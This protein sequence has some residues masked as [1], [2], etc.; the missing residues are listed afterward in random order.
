MLDVAALKKVV[1]PVLVLPIIPTRIKPGTKITDL[2]LVIELVRFDLGQALRHML[3]QWFIVR[4]L[5]EIQQAYSDA[6][7][8]N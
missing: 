6:R 1:F 4:H 3:G 5:F 2:E 8:D 7:G